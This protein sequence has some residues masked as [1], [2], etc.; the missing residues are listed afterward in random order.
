MFILVY[1]LGWVPLSFILV[2]HLPAQPSTRRA[3]R[4]GR[5]SPDGQGLPES[6]VDAQRVGFPS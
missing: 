4:Q 6:G 2:Y 3:Q 1:S 5:P